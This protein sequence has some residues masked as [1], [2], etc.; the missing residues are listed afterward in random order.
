[1]SRSSILVATVLLTAL[2]GGQAVAQD[3]APA[4]AAPAAP[5]K[6]AEPK[7]QSKAAQEKAAQ[8]KPAAEKAGADKGAGDKGSGDKGSG[9]K[10]VAAAAPAPQLPNGATSISETYGDWTVACAIENSAKLCTLGQSQGNKQTGERTF[11]F[12]MR[13][14]KDGQTPG[15]ILVPFGLK[16]ES[17][18]I[19]KL[20]DKDLGRGLRFSTCVR[21]GCLLPFSFPTVATDAMKTAK[22]LTVAALNFS[23]GEPVTFTVSLNGF[24][25]GLARL[26]ELGR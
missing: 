23:N 11:V 15:T 17:G 22:T 14:S 21:Q 26:A 8:E 7:S 5:V 19:L 1:M 16:L 4:S 20:D 9:D 3:S 13:S 2:A 24:E 10:P 25:P 18:A 6:H 12:E